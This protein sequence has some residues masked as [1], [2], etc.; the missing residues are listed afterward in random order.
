MAIAQLWQHKVE[1]TKMK[2]EPIVVYLAD[3]TDKEK[4][5]VFEKKM[6]MTQFMLGTDYLYV[7]TPDPALEKNGST[8]QAA[9]WAGQRE[10]A[11]KKICEEIANFPGKNIHF[12]IMAPCRGNLGAMRKVLTQMG[13]WPLKQTFTI[14]IYSGSFNMRGMHLDDLPALK[15]IAAQAAQNGHP[16]LDA[17]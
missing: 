16:M 4:G 1:T 7:L 17:A 9:H 13:K 2:R 6:L 3:F 11:L 5:T 12:Y 15:E 10:S 8:K 14:S